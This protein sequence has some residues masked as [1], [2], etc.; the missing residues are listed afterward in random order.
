MSALQTKHGV[1]GKH[2][3]TSYI[4]RD[5]I[6]SVYH[7]PNG[8]RVLAAFDKSWQ[9]LVLQLQKL[10]SSACQPR[11]TSFCQKLA[12]LGWYALKSVYIGNQLSLASIYVGCP[13]V[14]S[15]VKQV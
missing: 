12:R 4:F 13:L 1:V 2:I 15:N 11:R 3:P 9:A 7:H 8:A 5:N 6:L 10:G 14:L